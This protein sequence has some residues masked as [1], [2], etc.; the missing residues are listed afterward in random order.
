YNLR[1]FLFGEHEKDKK[2]LNLALDRIININESSNIYKQNEEIDFNEYFDDIVGVTVFDKPIQKVKL[3]IK[4]E[5][6]P[7]IETKPIHGSQMKPQFTDQ[8]VII[9]LNLI[10]NY[11][12]IAVLLSHGDRLMVLQPTE[13]VSTMKERINSMKKLYD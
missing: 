12:F 9:E 6:W 3:L 4:N 8:G 10:I 7:Y 1:W 11:E 2:V 13:L 5:L